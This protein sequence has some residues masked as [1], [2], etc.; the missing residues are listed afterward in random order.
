MYAHKLNIELGRYNNIE[1]SE[2]ICTLCDAKEIEDEYH[3]ILH[4]PRYS[5]QKNA[6]REMHILCST[7]IDILMF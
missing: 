5:N 6:I 7:T 4:S 2:R 3:F 1:R